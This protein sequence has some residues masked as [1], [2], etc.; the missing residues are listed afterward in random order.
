MPFSKKAAALA[1]GFVFALSLASLGQNAAPGTSTGETLLI[2]DA[3]IDWIEKSDVAALREGVISKMEL[4]IGMPV[5]EGKPIGYLHAEIAE[6]TVAKAKTAVSFT[7]PVEKAEAQKELAAAVLATS[8][9]LNKRRPGMVSDEEMR[10]AEA[11]LKVADAMKREA[12]EKIKLD[13]AELKLA[14]RALEEHK[15]VAPFDGIIVER[16]KNRGESVRANEAVVTLGNL[17][18]LRA[19]FYIPLEHAYRVKEGQIV[20]LQLRIT[21]TRGTPLPIEQ[22]RFRGKISFVD[23]QVQ[24]VAETAVRVHADFENP[25]HELRPGLK[26]A[27]TIYLGTDGQRAGNAAVG[28]RTPNALGR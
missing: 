25:D 28:V 3:T 20:D 11:E 17:D 6:L 19:W 18:K 8:H 24:P 23:P 2:D 22:K 13:T 7:A 9:R 16:K 5:L 14:E 12:F 10:K 4:Q 1:A 26:A 15:I 21:G 27:V